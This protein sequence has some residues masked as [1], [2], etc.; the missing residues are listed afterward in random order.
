MVVV[1]LVLLQVVMVHLVKVI[2]VG[3]IFIHVQ[4]AVVEQVE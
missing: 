2:M 1:V 3:L 4:V